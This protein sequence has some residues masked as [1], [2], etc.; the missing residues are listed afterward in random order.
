MKLNNTVVTLALL[1]VLAL[2]AF[3]GGLLP[4]GD[5]VH[6]ADPDFGSSPTTVAVLENTPPGV[7]IGDPISATDADETGDAAIEFGNTL[8]YSLQA[9]DT[10]EARADA[11][12]FDIDSSTGQLIT[13][14]PLDADGDKTTYTVTVR[15]DDGETRAADSPC[16]TCTRDVTITVSPLTNEAPLAPVPPT[17]VSG[18]DDVGTTNTDEST[19]SLKVVW[20]PPNNTGRPVIDTYVVEYKKSTGTDFGSTG[21]DIVNLPGHDRHDLGSGGRHLLRRAGSGR[22]TPTPETGGP[23]SLVGTGL[24][25]KEGNIPPALTVASPADAACGREHA[26]GADRR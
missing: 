4:A 8:T 14:A 26:R 6:A 7:N 11:A 19:T 5:P 16:G 24:T 3:A 21:V 20:H 15:V 18:P 12:A 17:V 9:E 13:K 25:N 10:D 23:W 22:R 2:A 1:G